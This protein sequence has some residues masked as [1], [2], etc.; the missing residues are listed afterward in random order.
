MLPFLDF[1]ELERLR[2]DRLLED[3]VVWAMVIASLGFRASCA[4]RT[5]VS[6]RFTPHFAGLNQLVRGPQ[7]HTLRVRQK[8]IGVRSER[9]DVQG[10][11]SRSKNK[12]RAVFVESSRSSSRGKTPK[13]RGLARLVHGAPRDP[14]NNCSNGRGNFARPEAARGVPGLLRCSIRVNAPEDPDAFRQS[15]IQRSDLLAVFSAG[16]S[17]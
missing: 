3:R 4:F 7:V 5:G 1:V 9:R 2:V 14:A 15:E 8:R 11:G 17:G 6:G 16:D 10:K 13:S 12:S